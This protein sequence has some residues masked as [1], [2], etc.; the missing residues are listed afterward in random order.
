MGALLCYELARRL[1]SAGFQPAHI[2]VS[3]RRA[4]HLPREGAAIHLMSDDVLLKAL[5]DFNG[6]PAR[7]LSNGDWARTLIPI[8]RADSAVDETYV[9]ENS[10]RLSCN[11]SAFCGS[12]D[13]YVRI[14]QVH[15]WSAHTTGR[16]SLRLFPGNHFFVKTAQNAVLHTI[17]KELNVYLAGLK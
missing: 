8:V 1:E 11:T 10:A 4:P 7:I 3:A 13:S 5:H 15:A 12:E 17:Q 6:V 16:F 2:F 9:W 14:N